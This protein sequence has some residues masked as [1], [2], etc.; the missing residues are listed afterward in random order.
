MAIISFL[1]QTLFALLG[2]VAGSVIGGQVRAAAMGEG[3]DAYS[4]A[5][6]QA[7]GETMIAVKPVLTNIAPGLAL[8]MLGKP[9]WLWAFLGGLAAAIAMGD[10]FEDQLMASLG[11]QPPPLELTSAE[12]GPGS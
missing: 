1:S 11:M 2:A 9:R 4:L 5:H 3:S 6:D 7:D 8:A 10:R 12:P